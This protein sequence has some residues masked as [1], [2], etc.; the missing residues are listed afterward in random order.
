MC[1]ITSEVTRE[2]KAYGNGNC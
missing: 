1:V 2:N